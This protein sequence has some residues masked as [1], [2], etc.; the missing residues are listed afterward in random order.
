MEC[1]DALA[2]PGPVLT[3]VVVSYEGRQLRWLDALRSQYVR[4]LPN[5]QKARLAARIGVRALNPQSDSD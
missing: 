2:T 1:S 5:R 3:R 4:K